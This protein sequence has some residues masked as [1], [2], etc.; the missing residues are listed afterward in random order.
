MGRKIL[1]AVILAVAAFYVTGHYVLPPGYHCHT[2]TS[3]RISA[4]L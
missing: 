4:C 3:G 2:V 1:I